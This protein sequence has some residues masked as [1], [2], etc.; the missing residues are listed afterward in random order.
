MRPSNRTAA[1]A[2]TLDTAVT[3]QGE[4]AADTIFFGRKLLLQLDAPTRGRLRHVLLA[5]PK[6]LILIQ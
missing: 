5:R 3:Y 1:V 4:E 6:E 2:N